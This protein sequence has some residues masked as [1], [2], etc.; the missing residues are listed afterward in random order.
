MWETCNL[1]QKGMEIPKADIA[2]SF[3]AS[4]VRMLV[5]KAV[6]A[7]QDVGYTKVVLAGG[8]AANS[9]LRNEI[10]RMCA[11]AQIRLYYP[12][13]ILCTDNAAMIGA[14]GFYTLMGGRISD[15][16]LNAFATGGLDE[17]YRK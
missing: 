6:R 11:A 4:V 9:R 16:D 8:V 5:E 13:P 17:F 14:A 2:A 3:Q 15:I 7:A 12:S 10:E 1:E